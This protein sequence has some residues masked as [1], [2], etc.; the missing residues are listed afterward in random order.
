MAKTRTIVKHSAPKVS[1]SR[2]DALVRTRSAAAQRTRQ[3]AAQRAGSL[4]GIAACALV[5]YL[6]K[7]GKMPTFAGFEPTLVGGLTLGFV[8]PHFVKG[9]M[10]QMS[11][12][13]GAA[14]SGVAA[15]KIG[16]GAPIRSVIGGDDDFGE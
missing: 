11:A 7:Q 13:A 3:I 14:L 2:Y 9:K 5:G 4:T 6:E 1:K 12:E 10:G 16:T 15:Y 8:V